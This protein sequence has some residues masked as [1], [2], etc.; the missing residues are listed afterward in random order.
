MY[1]FRGGAERDQL[2]ASALAEVA[3][4][5]ACGSTASVRSDAAGSLTPDVVARARELAGIWFE[6]LPQSPDAM[7]DAPEVEC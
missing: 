2:I 5:L 4:R 1:Q 6:H 3:V 7:L